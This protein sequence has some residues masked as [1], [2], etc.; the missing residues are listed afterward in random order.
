MK[1]LFRT[2]VV[3]VLVAF[4]FTACDLFGPDSS[5]ADN[6]GL[7]LC[8][9][10]TP[11]AYTPKGS[12][13]SRSISGTGITTELGGSRIV[14]SEVE[15]VILE[16]ELDADSDEAEDLEAG[17]V[18][19]NLPLDGSAARLFDNISVPEALYDALRIEVDAPKDDPEY[20]AFFAKNHADWPIDAC[21]RITGT[22]QSGDD[23]V[24]DFVYIHEGFDVDLGIEF[25]TPLQINEEEK[26]IVLTIDVSTWFLNEENNGL[27]NPLEIAGSGSDDAS[28]VEDNIE[29]SFDAF[30]DS[31]E[32]LYW[33]SEN[34]KIHPYSLIS[35]YGPSARWGYP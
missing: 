29:G 18:L 25:E 30:E 12:A 14:V 3:S 1:R 23:A 34:P 8:V 10:G 24:E 26:R 31:L 22:Y 35:L 6:S 16:L 13:A 15:M 19:F 9:T 11:N 33:F 2:L 20:A 27:L 21:I 5:G 17:P 32:N 7:S 4:V 28:I